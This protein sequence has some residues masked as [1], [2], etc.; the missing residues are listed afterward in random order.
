MFFFTL[1]IIYIFFIRW[2]TKTLR[3]LANCT[4]TTHIEMFAHPC[5][6]ENRG[7]SNRKTPL[8][9]GLT[10]PNLVSMRHI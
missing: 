6:S 5:F 4:P 10:K 8:F 7:E 1:F 9:S 2:V 3:S